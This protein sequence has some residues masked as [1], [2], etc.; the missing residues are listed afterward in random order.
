MMKMENRSGVNIPEGSGIPGGM[1]EWQK[2][3][4]NSKI[5]YA[6]NTP[7]GEYKFQ[8]WFII[9]EDGRVVDVQPLS[10]MN[11]GMEKSAVKAIR[12]SSRWSPA[13]LYNEPVKSIQKTTVC[14]SGIGTWK[15]KITSGSLSWCE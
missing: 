4:Q 6:R 9:D 11:Y 10:D 15:E 8:I 12:K 1:M 14:Y 3:I 7:P 5:T 2:F 13:I